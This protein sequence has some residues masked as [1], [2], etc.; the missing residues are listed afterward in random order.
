MGDKS[1]LMLNQ[2]VIT[3]DKLPHSPNEKD[4]NQTN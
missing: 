1:R 2:I 4:E 3:V